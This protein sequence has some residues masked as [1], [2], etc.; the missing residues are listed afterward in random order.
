M[1]TISIK[2]IRLLRY[3]SLTFCVAVCQNG[4]LMASHDL[5]RDR[6]PHQTALFN[7][8]IKIAEVTG[9]VMD[10]NGNKLPGVNI[11]LKNTNR[12]TTSDIDGN[13][14]IT[15]DSPQDVLVMSFIGY[16]TQEVV[17]GNQKNISVRL[18][19]DSQVLSEVVVTALGITREK[20]SLGYATQQI[21][22]ATVNDSPASNFVNNLSGKV[23]G[24][25]ISSAGGVGSSSRITI[26]G[27]S[28]LSMM[29]NQPL[30]IIDGVPVGND[31]TSNT[32]GADYGNSSSE[33]NPA[34]IESINVLKGP[35]AAALYG[36]RAARGAIVITTKK[37]SNRKGMGVSFN[38]Y[39]FV[40]EVGRL[41]KFQ[42]DFGQGNYPN[43][44][45]DDYDESWGPRLNTGSLE[46][47]FDSPTT[48]GFRAAD[49]SIP[50]RGDIIKTPWI[51]QPNN[52]KDFFTS[53]RKYYNN[54][55]FTGG[56]ENGDYRLSLTSLN[57]KG[58]IPNND[59]NRYQ[60]SLNSSYKLSKKLTSSININ[61]VRQGSENR[62]DN[63]YGRNTFM[64]FFTWMGRN[65]NINSLKNY[66]QPGLEGIRQFQ[67]NYGENHNNPFF[68]QYENTKGQ[69][70]D[71]VY[72]N[73]ALE[74][75]FNDHFKLKIRSAADLYND[76]RPMR[77][78]VSTVDMESGRYSI[79]SMKNEERNTDFLLTYNNT[80]RGGDFGYNV[81]LGGNRFDSNSHSESTTA[82]QLLI[83]GI[84]T[85]QNT[86]S[87]LIGGSYSY[88]KRINSLYAVANL[89][90]KDYVYLD[91]NARNDW[92]STLPKNSN[93][94][95][96]P[97]LGINT[98]LKS[99]FTLPEGISQAQLR[100]TWAQ[101]GNDTGPYSIY[102]TYGNT[103][104]WGSSYALV[105]PDRL[106]NPNLKPEITNTYEI[107]VALGFLQ[108]RLGIDVTYYDIRAKNQI[109]SLP[110]AQSSGALS[111]QINAGQIKNT[112][113]EIVLN[114]T[115]IKTEN[116]KWNFTLNWSHNT[117]KIV[118]LTDDVKKIVQ[119]APGE[120]ASI[121]AREGEKMGAIWGPG[122][123]RVAEG[124]MKGEI[125][126]F[127]DAYPRPT[128]EDIHL[129]NYNPD[130]IG[131]FYNQL[132]YRNFSLSFLFG[133]QYGGSFISRFYNK[134]A[135]AGQLE[136][137]ALGRVARVPGT[138]YENPY[139]IPGA[140]EM[141]DGTY[142]PNNVSTDGT[143]SEGVYGTSAR[144]FIKKP[145][146]HI[147]EAQ[148][149]SA[150]YFKLR[151][152]SFGYSLPRKWVG[153]K[154]IKNAK[155]SVT[156]RNLWL[157]TPKSNKH[158]D[159][160][161]ATATAGNGLIPGFEN[162]STPATK[163]LGVSLN[164]NF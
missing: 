158:F 26:R 7:E 6:T 81:S 15:I 43:G 80:I 152:L 21:S 127:K 90:Y 32:G 134:A 34:D 114:G 16:K 11:M 28:S 128:S 130:W 100:G 36:S 2:L 105:G 4:S 8:K 124:P 20:K 102:N 65:V 39:L 49:V 142:Q 88:Q 59:L 122:Y 117:G 62:P 13:F 112:G 123:Q 23:A 9:T 110:L 1:G 18:E 147:S 129:G 148:L 138:E 54:L 163:E 85:I 103:S 125:I 109:I 121:Q 69:N 151:E 136:E 48:N 5:H 94:Y 77:A 118:T 106:L 111:K 31:G 84:Y 126:I 29:S 83:P 113:V 155:I 97:S 68:L 47:Q 46:A 17:V 144:Y 108:N 78:A 132:S 58:V 159:P 141:G 24:V 37:G 153:E 156:G 101:V 87:P 40:E 162:M 66:W 35:A 51:S 41:P 33:I 99:I 139:Y 52:I 135:G 86:A 19:E 145:L 164:L 38:S 93:S 53:G 61:Y 67:Y 92:S 74:Y 45:N 157:F 22:G 149:F 75:A 161:V 42:N 10:V 27:E 107:G 146:D 44:D 72:G 131:G 73:I 160:E 30:F 63:G 91:L 64:Y 143:Y 96:Y 95:F 70:K 3:S 133:G 12:G 76:F 71:R 140:A 25:N 98:N 60:V 116:F 57:E 115:P 79:T 82:P 104:P 154:F 120:N 89:N 50:N 56:N 119:A 150:T 55:A 137:S 14:N